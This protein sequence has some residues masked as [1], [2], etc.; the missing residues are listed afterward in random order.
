MKHL[1]EA[2]KDFF[3]SLNDEEPKPP[4]HIGEAMSCW[5]YLTIIEEAVMLEQACLN[6]TNDPELKEFLEKTMEGA[7]SQSRRLKDFMQHEGV[8]LPPASEP[9]PLSDPDAVPLGAKLTDNE[10]AN[11]ISVK[12]VSSIVTCATSASQSVRNDVSMMF[13]EFQEETLIYGILN[14]TLMRKRGWLKI[15]PYYAPSG[16]LENNQ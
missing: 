3:G 2:L 6:S 4:L 13:V 5:L 14:K 12:L 7:S 9:K 16:L 11:L 10:I 15:P 1:F 8:T